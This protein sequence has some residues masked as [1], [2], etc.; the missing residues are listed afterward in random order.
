MV[1]KNQELF[2]ERMLQE[3]SE[4]KERLIKLN[5]FIES[6]KIMSLD[7]ANRTLLLRQSDIM[8]SYLET[9]SARISLNLK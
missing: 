8:T 3:Q 6:E 2:V 9:L 5:A 4:L 1:D 7:R